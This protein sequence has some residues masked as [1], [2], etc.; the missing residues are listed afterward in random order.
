M[1]IR[2]RL[3]KIGGYFIP[4]QLIKK[5]EVKLNAKKDILN[6]GYEVTG[7]AGGIGIGLW[8]SKP[9]EVVQYLSTL[10]RVPLITEEN[11]K[12]D[13]DY[14]AE[15]QLEATSLKLYP[16]LSLIYNLFGK[17]NYSSPKIRSRKFNRNGISME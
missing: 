8:F 15:V 17:W 6:G 5:I 2:L 13:S 7:V 1:R 3:F 14:F 11:L 12:P 10:K 16:P 4:D 9:D